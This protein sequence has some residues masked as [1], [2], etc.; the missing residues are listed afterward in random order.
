MTAKRWPRAVVFD[1]DG[2]LVDSAPDIA[3]ALNDARATIGGKP[4]PVEKVHEFIGGGSAVTIRR[5]LVADGIALAP[6]QETALLEHFIVVYSRISAE[7]RGLYDGAHDLL[8][9]LKANGSAL[10]LCTNKPEPVTRIAV[11]ALRITPYFGSIVGARDDLP[12]KPDPAMLRLVLDQLGVLPRD[13]VMIG[14][15][16]ADVGV[17][18]ALGVPVL[19]SANGY[20]KTPPHQLGADAVFERLADIPRLIGGLT[21]P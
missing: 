13:A 21:Q 9:G 16:A 10:G 1:L 7:G 18:R 6:V 14:D 5:A 15:S 12:K 8:A 20:T 4:F 3:D 2:T 11:D 19:V 17:A